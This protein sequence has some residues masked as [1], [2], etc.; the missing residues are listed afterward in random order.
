MIGMKDV[1]VSTGDVKSYL[2]GL[3]DRICLALEAEA[4]DQTF[5]EDNWSRDQHEPSHD[6][7]V[8]GGGGR[9]KVMA[10]GAVFEQAGVNFSHVTGESLPPSA[11]AVRPDLAGRSF[12]ALGV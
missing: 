6:A 2:L 11:T 4:G 8:L 3:Q 7:P 10:D 9:S 12:K 5:L 1:Q